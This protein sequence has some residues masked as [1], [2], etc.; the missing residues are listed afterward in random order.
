MSNPLTG[1]FEA[2][3]QI[4]G[5]TVNRLTASMHQNTNAAPG[6]PSFPHALWMRI[7]DG[8]SVDGVRGIVQAQLGVPQV[9]LING[10]TDRFNLEV[11]VRARYTADLGTAPLPQFIHGTVRAQ[12]R[13]QDIDPNCLG[14]SQ[15]ASQY[16]WIRVVK[17][18]VQFTGTAVDDRSSIVPI[19]LNPAT[20]AAT[21][22]ANAARIT[23][24]I[25]SLLAARFAAV[26][27]PV[28]PQFHRGAMRSLVAP[29]G[30]S[31]VAMPVGLTGDPVGQITSI[32]NLLTNGSDFAIAVTRDY[33]LSLAQP[34]LDAIAGFNPTIGLHVHVNTPWPAPDIDVSTVYRVHVNAPTIVWQAYGS[35]AVLTIKTNG[36][37]NT[38]SILPN[39]TFDI[40]QDIQ[41]TFDAG[42]ETLSLSPGSRSVTAHA[43]GIGS[44]AIADA[45]SKA[46]TN[47][48]KS[49]INGACSNAQPGLDATIARKQTLIDQLRTIDTQTNADVNSAEF[50]P[51]GIVL[52][53]T[54]AL[55]SRLAPVV[56]FEKTVEHDGFSAL[57]A[58]IPGGRV[59][60]LEW[61][62]T[63]TGQNAPG[64]ATYD[65]RFVVR[66]PKAPTSRWAQG[67]G[68]TLPLPGIDGNGT[69]CLAVKGVQID[70]VTGSLVTIQTVKH[71]QRFGL[72]LSVGVRADRAR[73]LIRDLPDLS[74]KVP[75]AHL[76]LYAVGV[77]PRTAAA[78]TLLIYVD[79]KWDTEIATVLRAGLDGTRRDNAGLVLL[80]LFKEGILSDATSALFTSIQ[81]LGQHLGIA[82]IVNEDVQARWS[83]AYAL[84]TESDTPSWRLLSPAG[85]VTWMHDGPVTPPQ[86]VNALDQCLIP[87][88]PAAADVVSS[89]VFIGQRISAVALHPSL[90]DEEGNCPPITL[91]RMGKRQSVVS[92]VQSGS[93]AS[94]A[95]LRQLAA[96]YADAGDEAPLI[97]VVVDAV[98]DREA[99]RMKH[100]LGLDVDVRADSQGV[101]AARL[102]IR[103][104]PTTITV[105]AA[106]VVAS[107]DTA[108]NGKP[109]GV[110]ERSETAD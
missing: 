103:R 52:R 19:P 47:A 98:D 51:D 102:G 87:S 68:P 10:A 106:G 11:G 73:L 46:V 2:V 67:I 105:N 24:Q 44:G 77:Q 50:L 95:H 63:A 23:R 86:L 45:V 90:P 26:P 107:V 36:S 13:I 62:W 74:E 40:S 49:M 22:A 37:A 97:V 9:Q 80:V 56:V 28:S 82:T 31:A 79:R 93:A 43:S 109:S 39:A 61:T 71:C 84:R 104:W 100:E 41:I 89:G 4:D 5:S 34:T 55:T 12:Y 85:D 110:H 99:Q 32:G 59:D 30:A 108:I 66:R 54:I 25:A 48:V 15:K 94:E 53:G 27:H 72:N 21:D 16:L 69:L 38:D 3:L 1:D 64:A 60:K 20:A 76:P 35:F 14:W 88:P 8:R 96:Q 6:I 78:N 29:D 17:D 81:E 65:D 18:S 42:S 58:W 92:F 33:I 70:A 101:I 83:V 7:G 91:G 57:T 75:F